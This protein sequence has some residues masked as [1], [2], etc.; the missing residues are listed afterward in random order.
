VRK[1]EKTN[2]VRF[3]DIFLSWLFFYFF[4]GLR[5]IWNFVLFWHLLSFSDFP[6]ICFA[7]SRYQTHETRM[8]AWRSTAWGA[9]NRF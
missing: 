5:W 4:G 7:M 2:T 8:N 9:F 1:V 3:H 6:G